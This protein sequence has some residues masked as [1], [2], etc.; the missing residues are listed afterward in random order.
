VIRGFNPD[1]HLGV[2]S[3]PRSSER[4]RN[5]RSRSRGPLPDAHVVND[6]LLAHLGEAITSLIKVQ[7]VW[8]VQSLEFNNY[9]YAHTKKCSVRW[10]FGMNDPDWAKTIVMDSLASL[11]GLE[12]IRI[13]LVAGSASPL[14]LSQLKNMR[15]VRITGFCRQGMIPGLRT[16][17]SNSPR[18]TH[19]DLDGDSYLANSETS[20]LHEIFDASPPNSPLA[21]THLNL[22]S[23]CVRLDSKTLLPHLGMLE[24]LTIHCNIDTRQDASLEELDDIGRDELSE[25][26]RDYCSTNDEIWDILRRE[27]IYL[28]EVSTDEV[29]QALL[30]YLASYSGL[31]KLTLNFVTYNTSWSDALGIQ[32]YRNVLLKHVHTLS[33]LE[34]SPAFEGKWCFG[35]HNIAIVLQCTKLVSLKMSINSD[36]IYGRYNIIVST[37]TSSFFPASILNIE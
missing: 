34:I 11:P 19:L 22:R 23:W 31:K 7:D 10:H 33:A 35:Q 14:K 28:L 29:S 5:S 21:L 9:F 13:S 37:P 25:R 30:D 27:Q 15:K 16:L 2:G 17:I 6:A 32:F 1:S 8:C 12:E 3:R 26:T 18:L 24:S 4:N 36:D 20:T